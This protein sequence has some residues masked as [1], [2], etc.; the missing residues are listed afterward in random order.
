MIKFLGEDSETG[1]RI[2]GLIIT[3]DNVI[4]L[5]ENMPIHFHCEQMY[6]MKE[7]AIEEVM[8]MYYRDIDEAIA[9]LKKNGMISEETKTHAIIIEESTKH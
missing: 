3:E 8:I 7:I 1:R 6:G 5:K 9:G 2:L 4:K